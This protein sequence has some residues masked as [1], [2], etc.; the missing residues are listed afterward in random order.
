[1]LFNVNKLDLQ[2]PIKWAGGKKFIIEKIYP[3]LIENNSKKCFI[4]CFAGS[5]ALTLEFQPKKAIINDLNFPLI[6]MWRIIKERPNELCEKLEI[7]SNN[8]LYNNK[9]K[10][11]LIKKEYNDMKN[12]ELNENERILLACY[13]IYLNKRSF[14]G[15]YRE[16]RSGIYNVTFRLYKNC[17]MYDKE[18]IMRLSKYFNDNDITFK[19]GNY[20]DINIPKESL[21]YIDPPYYPSETSDFTSYTKEGFCINNQK[22]LKNFCDILGKKGIKFIESNSPCLEIMDMY[23]KYN[24]ETFYILRSMRSAKEGKEEKG[25]EDNEILIWN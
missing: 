4:E 8:K 9:N 12:S 2:S 18:N 15:L 17:V 11:D 1:M 23:G 13:F 14:N 24:M 20:Y 21:V 22:E 5:I 7:Y 16:N 10:F 25:K 19:C 6:N 3:L